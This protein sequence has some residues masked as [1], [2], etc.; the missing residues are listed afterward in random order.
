M[1]KGLSEHTEMKRKRVLKLRSKLFG[2]FLSKNKSV[3]TIC[4]IKGEWNGIVAYIKLQKS[5]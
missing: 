4:P 2:G 1:W 3:F 5:Q